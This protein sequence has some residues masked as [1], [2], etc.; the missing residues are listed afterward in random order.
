MVSFP[1]VG[2]ELALE[3]LLLPEP[4]PLFGGVGVST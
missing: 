2:V 3:L 4:P 1:L